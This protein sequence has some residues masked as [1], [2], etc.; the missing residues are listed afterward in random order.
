MKG[1]WLME[2][3]RLSGG[4]YGMLPIRQLK[5]KYDLIHPDQPAY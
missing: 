5:Y 3:M 1:E 2:L 4:N